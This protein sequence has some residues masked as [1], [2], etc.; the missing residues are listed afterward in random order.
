MKRRMKVE[1]LYFDGCPTYK[2]AM[3]ILKECVHEVDPTI[4]IEKIKVISNDHARSLEFLGS[5]TIRI[6]GRDIE[7][8][9]Q[10]WKDFGLRCRV[11]ESQEGF[12]GIPTKEMILKALQR[13]RYHE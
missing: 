8:K 2:E 9:A 6:N 5:P 3:K 13:G 1:L 10:G 11:Y 4:R 7:E 12:G